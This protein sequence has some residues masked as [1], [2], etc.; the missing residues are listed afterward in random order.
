MTDSHCPPRSPHPSGRAPARASL[1]C[2]TSHSPIL[3]E[4]AVLL[5]GLALATVATWPT[6]RETLRFTRIADMTRDD[7]VYYWNFWWIYRALFDLHTNPLF[8]S[9]IFYPYGAS[10]AVSP[11]ALPFAVL[12]LPLQALWGTLPGSIFTVKVVGLLT[13][14]LALH[15]TTL[16]LRRMGV[17]LKIA[18]LGG[19]FYAFAPFRLIHLTRIHY[20]A[21]ALTPYCVWLIWGAMRQG[22]ASRIIGAGALIALAGACDFSLLPETMLISL[23]LWTMEMFRSS[24]RWLATR[25]LAA[26][27]FAAL[28]ILSPIL[29]P[30]FLEMRSN[31][32][33]AAAERLEFSEEPQTNQLILS[34]DLNNLS[35]MVSPVLYV[36]LV[37]DHSAAWL[38]TTAIRKIYASFRP[39][40]RLHTL[41]AAAAFL[42]V[43]LSGIACVL[44]LRRRDTWAFAFL[45]TLGVVLALGP[46]RQF[47]GEVVRMPYSYFSE[48]VPGMKAGR[49]PAAHLRLFHLGIVVTAAVGI[50]NSR[51]LL[52]A[53]SW[54]AL[55][56]AV[57]GWFVHPF[58]YERFAEEHVFDI[59][60][61]DPAPGAVLHLPEGREPW[62]RR[63]AIGQIIHQ[64]PLIEAPLTRQAPAS[65][66]FFDE[67]PLVPRLMSPPPPETPAEEIA[68]QAEE[69]MA[70]LRE[71][72]VRF[73]LLRYYLR[74]TDPVRFEWLVAYLKQHPGLELRFIDNHL[75]VRVSDP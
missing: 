6:L 70:I 8:C 4:G 17:P 75:L 25:R 52:G 38:G 43:V 58:V 14:P 39:A 59:M 24:E 47:M 60:A 72:Q 19:A 9:Q 30:F 23:C 49:Y 56:L 48:W 65:R 67:L 62:M 68:R 26:T 45:A 34:P 37:P 18:F 5:A 11:L 64:R 27:A 10:L 21:G 33:T 15:G 53:A 46:Y 50:A 55:S 12:S 20:L 7:Y 29:V 73:I 69:N 41:E 71:H 74:I 31:P 22:G 32:G 28:V 35:F 63:M 3:R 66:R 42:I 16:L 44:G 57:A 13:F 1:G 40:S 2:G 36:S 61:A 51:R 54:G